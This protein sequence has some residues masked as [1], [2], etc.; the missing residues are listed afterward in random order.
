[1]VLRYLDY[2]GHHLREHAGGGGGWYAGERKVWRFGGVDFAMRWIPAGRF[3]MGA[4][5]DE[6]AFNWEN[7]QR[8][9]TITR[10]Y[11]M[12]ETPVTQGEYEAITGESPSR[13]KDVGLDAPVECVSWHDAA[14]FANRLSELEGVSACFVGDGIERKGVGDGRSDYLGCKGWRLSTEAEWECAARAGTRG[15]CYGALDDV[16]WYE[17]NSGG[18]THPVGQKQANA[19]GLHDMLGNVWEWCYDTYQDHSSQVTVDP[20][21]TMTSLSS[22]ERGGS[23]RFGASYARVVSRDGSAPTLRDND[24]GFRVVRSGF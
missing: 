10:G 5:E 15:A 18:Q 7:T 9:V 23:F 14:A 11:W 8:E 24:L 13:F 16:A 20:V 3:L 17:E 6:K 22:I 21:Q 4:G 1:M 12:G 2:L 19:W